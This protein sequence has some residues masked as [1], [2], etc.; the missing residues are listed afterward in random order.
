MVPPATPETIAEMGN[1][2]GRFS[3][4]F[5]HLRDARATWQILRIL[6][7]IQVMPVIWDLLFPPGHSQPDKFSQAQI[8]L[9]LAKPNFL[10]GDIWQP[11][12]YA[13][14]HA[15]WPHLILNGAAILLLGSKLEHIT[16]KRT[17]RILAI[18]AAL[19]GG[20]MFLALSRDTGT[21]P[22]RL[23]GS[24]AVCFAFLVLLTTLSP[25]SRFLPFFVS[26]KSLGMGVILANLILALLNPDLPTGP[27]ARLGTHLSENHFP[28]LFRIGHA[29]H[30]GGSLAGFFVGKFLLRPRVTIES[31]RR[32]REKREGNGAHARR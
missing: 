12:T 4:G 25:E 7:I 13:L 23:V 24:S 20:F 8:L 11:F 6:L 9:G 22:L 3:R 27:L 26:G 5:R 32:A 17:I 1:K 10:S 30:L 18:A 15:D 14:I 29:C 16:G 19:A 2:G 28:G 21:E 31:L